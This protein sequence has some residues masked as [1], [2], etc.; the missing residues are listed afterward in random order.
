MKNVFLIGDSIRR[1]APDSPGYGCF[2][3]KYLGEGYAV[4]APEENCRF[5]QYTQRYLFEWADKLPFSGEEINIVHWNNGLW[6]VCH[7]QGDAEPL[8]SPEL[9]RQTLHRTAARIRTVF[10]HARIVYALTTGVDESRTKYQHG[11]AMRTNAEIAFY[12]AIAVQVMAKEAIAVHPLNEVSDALPLAE[13]SDWV[14]YTDQGYQV[15]AE[16]VA[17]FVRAQ[18]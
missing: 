3:E 15:L 6:D 17:A 18:L 10:P 7:F 12:N 4:Y 11:T 1:G 16:A 13:H 5:A 8:I 14:H 2:V 9:Y